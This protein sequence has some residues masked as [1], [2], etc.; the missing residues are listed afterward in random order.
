MSLLECAMQDGS[1]ILICGA[2]RTGKTTL[3][4]ALCNFLPAAWRVVKIEDPEEIWIDR[5]T[6]QTVE[7]RPKVPGSEVPPYTLADGVDDAMRMSPDY[8]IVGEVRDG[9]AAMALL[10]ALMTGHAG[11]CTLH[12]DSPREA[13]ERLT[14]LMGSDKGVSPRDAARM[15]S[16][17]VDLLVQIGIVHEK[18]RVTSIASVDKMFKGSEAW[19]TPLWRL[20]ENTPA[21]EPGWVKITTT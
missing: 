2:T 7:A 21:G 18:R 4:S 5:K 16:A 1:R 14:T 8:L 11:A 15:I 3:L 17:S 6:V 20:D 12:A 19:F 10:R 13:F 9:H